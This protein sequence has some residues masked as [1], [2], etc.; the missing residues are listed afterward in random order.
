MRLKHWLIIMF[1]P[2]PF[3]IQVCSFGY[4][5]LL[6][7][8]LKDFTSISVPKSSSSFASGSTAQKPHVSIIRL[9][10]RAPPLDVNRQSQS[11]G[12][13]FVTVYVTLSVAVMG[14][15]VMHQPLWIEGKDI[16]PGVKVLSGP[17]DLSQISSH[18]IPETACP[19]SDPCYNAQLMALAETPESVLIEEAPEMHITY[20]TT[21]AMESKL[22]TSIPEN[23]TLG[24]VR[25]MTK[26]DDAVLEQAAA[27]TAKQVANG[28]LT[29]ANTQ[30]PPASL[31]PPKDTEH[32]HCDLDFVL[33]SN[34]N[35]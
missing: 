18:V 26:D 11:R 32:K 15:Q 22:K 33:Q 1:R 5:A 8:H 20:C 9:L 3:A 29:W 12:L 17:C 6:T 16:Q 34:G 25:D 19:N 4:S 27:T 13:N 35:F 30:Q 2:S 28:W 21:L 24:D 14:Y 23:V 7:I 10:T 31:Q